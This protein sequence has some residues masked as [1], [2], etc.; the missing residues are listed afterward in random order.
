MNSLRAFL[1][2][3]ILS[4]FLWSMLFISLACA[5]SFVVAF[6]FY[7]KRGYFLFGMDDIIYSLKAGVAAGVAAGLGIWGASKMREI[8][9]RE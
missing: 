4:V 1:K 5:A 3:L 6:L 7:W 2:V 8:D 9:N